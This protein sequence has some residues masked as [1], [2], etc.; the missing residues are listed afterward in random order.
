MTP[1]HLTAEQLEAGIADVLQSPRASGIVR[2]I[3][4]RPNVNEREMLQEAQLDTTLGL[5]GDNWKA[6][7]NQRMP[8]G[9]ANPEAQITIMNS[10]VAALV[11]QS[12]D[13]W[14]LAGDQIFADMNL[15]L[16]N[17]APGTRLRVGSAEL[18]V[19]AAPHTGCAKFVARFGPDAMKFVNSPQGRRLC[20]RGINAQVR[21]SGCFRIGDLLTKL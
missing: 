15:S 14:S 6:R 4:R 18:E 13:R 11:A 20:L 12:P 16:D 8:D 5:V 17:L 21:Q 9:Q 1:V 3:V 19:S 7:G 10:R 2:M